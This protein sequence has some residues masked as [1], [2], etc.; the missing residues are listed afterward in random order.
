MI[1]GQYNGFYM[2][3]TLSTA[4]SSA[5]NA[6]LIGKELIETGRVDVAIVG[7]S[8]CITKFH[9]NGFNTLMILDKTTVALSTKVVP[10]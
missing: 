9:L 8:E 2:M 5:A 3:T 4:C 1:A 6:I 10:D 7:G